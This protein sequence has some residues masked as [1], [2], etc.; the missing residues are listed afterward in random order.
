MV[1][2][3]SMEKMTARGMSRWGFLL[4]PPNWT[5]CS[6]PTRANTAPPS[7]TALRIPCRPKGAKPWL[8]KLEVSN[9]VNRRTTMVMTGMI[10]FQVV[11]ALLARTR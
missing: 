4:S 3:M 8:V 10:T 9:R 5:A 11:M 2:P 6:N 1:A 7:L